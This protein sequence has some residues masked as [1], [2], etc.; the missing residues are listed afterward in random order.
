V[1][2]ARIL[3]LSASITSLQLSKS[4]LLVLTEP[5]FLELLLDFPLLDLLGFSFLL[6]DFLLPELFVPEPECSPDFSPDLLPDILDPELCFPLPDFL[7]PELF[8]PEL[9]SLDPER[10]SC[11]SPE[12]TFTLLFEE[13]FFPDF[14]PLAWLPVLPSLLSADLSA[15]LLSP[16]SCTWVLPDF[17]FLSLLENV[18]SVRMNNA[19][20]QIN[21]HNVNFD[22]LSVF[23]QP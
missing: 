22:I 16:E 1:N 6:P 23:E 21:I 15:E 19:K 13:D 14:S 18:A 7:L 2:F 17:F 11:V 8:S 5:L 3:T 4:P 20:Q 12:P 10:E 9:S